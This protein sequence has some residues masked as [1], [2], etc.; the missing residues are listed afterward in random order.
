[1][2]IGRLGVFR[3]PLPPKDNHTTPS[4]SVHTPSTW[5]CPWQC[6]ARVSPASDASTPGAM[7]L[8][9]TLWQ[10]GAAVHA[11]ARHRCPCRA[12][13]SPAAAAAAVNCSPAGRR[14]ERDV[15]TALCIG[16]G[17]GAREDS[18]SSSEAPHEQKPSNP[19]LRGAG[20]A[21]AGAGGARPCA[22]GRPTLP[23][24]R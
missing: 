10:P 5:L 1:M 12:P 2:L 8:C 7:P 22:R 17:A 3:S 11:P 9:S 6:G 18:N 23:C 13:P 19:Y 21:A 16:F 20:R 14:R 24:S 15:V 4:I